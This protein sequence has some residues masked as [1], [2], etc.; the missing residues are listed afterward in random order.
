MSTNF[1]SS[2]SSDETRNVHTKTNNIEIMMGSETDKI[3]DK[4]FK[5]L[6]QNYQKDLEESMRGNNFVF[7][8]V[9]LL[10]KKS[11]NKS[12]R[13]RIIIYR[14]SRMVKK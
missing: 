8:S 13:N 1:I 14:F 5:S 11:K 9:D 6:L 10:S 7:N 12:K 2:N 3:I 4:L